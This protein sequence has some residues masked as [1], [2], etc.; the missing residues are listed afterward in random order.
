MTTS[1]REFLETFSKLKEDRTVL[2]GVVKVTQYSEIFGEDVLILEQGDI[3]VYIP[4]PEIELKR[5][6]KSLIGYVWKEIEFIVTDFNAEEGYVVG[7]SR[8]VKLEQRERM[9]DEVFGP[10]REAEV[11][12]VITRVLTFGAYVK[13]GEL[14]ALLQNKDFSNDHTIVADMH[15]EGD[16]IRVKLLRLSRSKVLVEAVEKVCG[17]TNMA[18]EDLEPGQLVQGVIRTVKSWGCFT[19]ILP[20]LDAVSPIPEYFEVEE[21]MK[22]IFKINQVRED[23]RVRGKIVRAISPDEIIED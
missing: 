20:M 10:N 1:N 5:V 8:E 6:T 22:V 12:A 16:V 13:I 18:F 21:G 23:G 19:N 17:E 9:V 4:R 15:K 3:K 14:S 2:K 7:S 11:D